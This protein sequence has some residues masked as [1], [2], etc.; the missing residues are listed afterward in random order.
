LS[1]ELIYFFAGKGLIDSNHTMEGDKTFKTI[2][3]NEVQSFQ[4][5]YVFAFEV[6]RA[7]GM[8]TKVLL[9]ELQ[10]LD[11]EPI[12]GASIDYGPHYVFKRADI[13]RFDL[14]SLTRPY[15][16][17]AQ[18]DENRK[19]VDV[20]EP[21]TYCPLCNHINGLTVSSF[22]C[23]PTVRARETFQV[24]AINVSSLKT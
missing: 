9:G 1:K 22:L 14:K 6:A 11:I 23:F 13:D 18:E 12:S 16:R 21:A 20:I 15:C 5:K 7:L 24:E 17:K 10:R 19:S 2:S 3:P 4:S 8:P